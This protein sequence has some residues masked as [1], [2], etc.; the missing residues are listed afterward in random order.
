MKKAIMW[1]AIALVAFLLLGS[2]ASI[3]SF[4]I[5]LPWAKED[6]E[7]P[8]KPE[9]VIKTEP[10]VASWKEL[11]PQSLSAGDA[12]YDEMYEQNTDLTALYVFS[13]IPAGSYVKIDYSFNHGGDPTEDNYTPYRLSGHGTVLFSSV[14]ETYTSERE[15][16]LAIGDDIVIARY[17]G[18]FYGE[19]DFTAYIYEV[20]N[21]SNGTA[22]LGTF[23]IGEKEYEYI[24]GMNM[25]DWIASKYNVDGWKLVG[26]KIVNGYGT[27]FVVGAS[28]TSV[29]LH[30]FEFGV[31]IYYPEITFYLDGILHTTDAGSTLEEYVSND[32]TYGYYSSPY[33]YENDLEGAD[34]LCHEDGTVV[35]CREVIIPGHHYTFG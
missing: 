17:D 19:A 21:E 7:T 28:K 1:I 22:K 11:T 13:D 14:D 18:A 35:D 8:E 5:D 23:K 3:G 33:L 30:E 6:E 4:E 20:E 32:S 31:D 29:I 15:I 2:L 16:F 34:R 9:E 25:G 10:L 26:E 27:Y 24:H 12:L